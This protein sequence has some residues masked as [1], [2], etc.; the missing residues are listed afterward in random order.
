M[1]FR[2][3]GAGGEAFAS[4]DLAGTPPANANGPRSMAMTASSGDTGKTVITYGDGRVFSASTGNASGT[5]SV[6]YIGG[7]AGDATRSFGFP[8]AFNGAFNLELSAPQ[9]T[10]L[11]NLYRNTLGTGLG[12]PDYDPATIEYAARSGATDLANIDAFVRGVKD[13][14]LWNSMVCWPLRSTQNAG[15]GTTAYSLGGLGAFNGT[16]VGGPAWDPAGIVLDGTD[17]YLNAGITYAYNADSSLI[18]VMQFSGTVSVLTNKRIWGE[19]V[20]SPTPLYVG[21]T[22]GTANS[23]VGGIFVTGGSGSVNVASLDLSAAPTFFASSHDSS[24]TSA[25]WRFVRNGA[26][27]TGDFSN[28]AT[29]SQLHL[30]AGQAIEFWSGTA[31]FAAYLNIKTSAAT[32]QSLRDLY[33][34]TLGTGLGLP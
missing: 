18:A 8:I 26:T 34:S 24:T 21:L 14:G 32:L 28:P 16:L 12:L 25:N 17:D 3:D 33:K 2:T 1:F 13:L 22:A 4:S 6:Y 19:S 10:A 30:G 31:A 5:N 15:T 29:T 9:V 27:G 7:L 11:H 23:T 20:N